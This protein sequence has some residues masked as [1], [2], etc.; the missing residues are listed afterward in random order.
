[1][2]RYRR[3]YPNWWAG[4]LLVLVAAAAPERITERTGAP[5]LR[6]P[7][8]ARV[9][10]TGTMEMEVTAYCQ[11]KVCCGPNA[12]GITASGQ[13]VTFHNRAFV[14]ADTSVL[15][16]YSR[17]IIPG[18]NHGKPVPVIDRGSAITGRA[19]DV[20]FPSHT[21]AQRWGRQTLAVKIVSV[22]DAQ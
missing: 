22:A 6:P 19:I 7:S 11:C 4:L 18:Y 3:G 14:A 13:P 9:A 2:A 8:P 20:Y 16:L 10:T 12:R 15:P 1:M 5:A 17:V 21:Q